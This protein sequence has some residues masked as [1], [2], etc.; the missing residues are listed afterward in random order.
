VL[1]KLNSQLQVVGKMTSETRFTII[2][3][4]AEIFYL[5]HQ[6][7][8]LKY[9]AS[10]NF[11]DELTLDKSIAIGSTV[12]S[13]GNFAKVE[14]GVLRVYSAAT[15]DV[16]WIYNERRVFDFVES[17][18]GSFILLARTNPNTDNVITVKPPF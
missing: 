3:A 15:G 16:L 6:G 4:N 1:Y 17:S 11:L 5:V 10:G 9:S 18:N 2:G 8:V 12:L 14:S 7:K 13:D